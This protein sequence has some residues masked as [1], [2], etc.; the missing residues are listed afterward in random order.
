[1]SDAPPERDAPTGG[2]LRLHLDGRTRELARGTSATFGRG[3]D[4]VIGGDDPPL[5][6]LLGRV[7]QH[8]D[9]WWLENVGR[10]L[11]ITVT[12]LESASYA[13]LAP[14][15]AMPLPFAHAALAFS[16][17]RR[18]YR[19]E[20]HQV[21]SG[22]AEAVPAVPQSDPLTRPEDFN[23]EQRALLLA[24]AEPRLGGPITPINLPSNR[25]LAERLGWSHA[26]LVRKL[27]HLCR[28]LDRAGV[29]GLVRSARGSAAERRLRLADF[30]V[31]SGLARALHR[32]ATSARPAASDV[33]RG[34]TE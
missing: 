16:T 2:T 5:P 34:T 26:K 9:Y 3:A 20:L 7:R 13:R 10:A 33:T 12:D 17:A 25:T 27:D 31:E 11:V 21:C 29:A 14:G 24:L 19:I 18:D 23:E 22:A 28:K 6:R 1:M 15:R 32:A 8:G 30:V 4:I